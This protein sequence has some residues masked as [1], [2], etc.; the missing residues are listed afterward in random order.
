MA[1][2]AFVL[3]P[4]RGLPRV[5]R[6]GALDAYQAVLPRPR[7]S[8]PAVIVA[9]DE[10]SLAERGQWPWPRTVLA[11]LVARVMEG[12]PAAIGIDILVP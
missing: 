3:G 6:L 4:E 12:G 2:V 5:V 9:I 8:A 11:D 7:A 1:L 10:A